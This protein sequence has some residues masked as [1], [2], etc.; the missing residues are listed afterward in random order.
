MMKNVL[1]K[2]FIIQFVLLS[3]AANTL[4]QQRTT[5]HDPLTDP[6]IIKESSVV[7]SI[8]T[9]DDF[10]IG[11]EKIPRSDIAGVVAGRLKDKPPEEQIVY[12]MAAKS[13]SYGTFVSVMD[14]IRATGVRRVGLTA[15]FPAKDKGCLKPTKDGSGEQDPTKNVRGS[16]HLQ[17]A[18]INATE[19]ILHVNSAVGRSQRVELNSTPVPL[20]ELRATLKALLE[21]RKDKV[22]IITARGDMPYCDVRRMIDV[23]RAAGDVA[24]KFKAEK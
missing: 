11:G 22:V 21:K 17:P 10:S 18:L 6:L 7:V 16:Q 14:A 1:L 19:I 15:Y 3:V 9:D 8:D 24:I 2:V 12:I 20:A 5:F 13:V 23:V 4:A